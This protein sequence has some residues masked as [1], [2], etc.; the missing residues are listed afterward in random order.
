MR[1]NKPARPHYVSKLG[2]ADFILVH[3]PQEIVLALDYQVIKVIAIIVT[4]SFPIP[5]SKRLAEVAP[6]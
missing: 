6:A 1:L 3:D 4:L 2:R 5:L